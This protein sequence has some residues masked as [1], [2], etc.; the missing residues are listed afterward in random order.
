MNRA[1][2]F[3]LLC[4]FSPLFTQAKSP[5]ALPE[6][7]TTKDVR[8]QPVKD[9]D[10]YFPFTPS[11]SK[12]EWE[13]RAKLVREELQVALGL[14][15]MPDK[16][17]LNA[18]IHGKMDMGDYTVEKV[19]FESMP[20][21]FVTGNLYR[22]KGKTGRVPGILN[23]HGHWANGRFYDNANG[24]AREIAEG[25]E[26]FEDSGRSPLQARCVQLARMGCVVFFYDM[27]G[28]ADSQQISLA[29]AHGFAKQRPEM[30]TAENWGLFS[31]QAET[32]LQSI[33]G[34]QTWNSIRALDFLLTLP[35]VDPEK[36]GCTGASGGGTQTFI[37][38]AIDPRL[39]VAF[40]AVMV[41]TAMQGGCT[42]ENSCLLRVDTG[43]VEIAA[44]FAPKALGMTAADDWTKEMPTKGFP[45][46]QKHWAMM[47]APNN[48]FLKP[49]LHFGHNYNHVSRTAMYNWMNRHFNLGLKEPVLEKDFRRLST[50][51]MTV[52]DQQ[53]PKP[54]G[55]PE[56]EKQLL[57]SW[58]EDAQ[59]KLE[60]SSASADDFRALVGPAVNAIIQRTPANA[61]QVE[62]ELVHKNDETPIVEMVGILKNKTRGEEVP[63]MAFYPK[64]WK[65]RTVIWLSED[66]KDGLRND[67][68][69]K[70]AVKRLV[71]GGCAVVGIDLL[72]QGELA[73]GGQ[74]VKTTR[75]VKNTR[76]AAAYTFGYNHTLFAQRVHDV[77]SL[78]S[79]IQNHER[80]SESIDIVALDN[81]GPI[82]A[83]ARAQAGGAIRRLAMDDADFRFGNLKEIHN[84]AFLPGGAK[85]GDLPGFLALAAPGETRLVGVD[86]V[87]ELAQKIY[88]SAGAEKAISAVK[89]NE[90]EVSDWI[91]Q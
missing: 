56:F 53:H 57:R 77:L 58:H 36:I 73:P 13:K 50:E 39:K 27:L 81:M 90:A 42:C 84:V 26:R 65:N 43:N 82:A 48:V 86:S 29:L 2:L 32:H 17:P 80:K 69:I 7:T 38:A 68:G 3:A 6:G 31:P 70:P 59:N 19:Y 54:L 18:V 89:A 87:P 79:F 44:L 4:A 35:D 24:I 37:L 71:E 9:L 34:L 52:W 66:G 41:S 11:T 8:L 21:F 60:K 15:P 23:P 14:W 85:Y 16:T 83:V 61:G 5:R 75:R 78:I 67:N 45:Q 63:V 64:E 22:P 12:E 30:N 91:L 46:L 51:E 25:A 20:G 33:M 40:P 62:F 1:I 49:A 76:E 28:N 47:G 74:M 72:Y 10:G 55:G 88:R